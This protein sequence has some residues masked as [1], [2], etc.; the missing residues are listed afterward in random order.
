[1]LRG[2]GIQKLFG[3]LSVRYDGD[4]VEM[5]RAAGVFMVYILLE[6]GCLRRSGKKL[7]AG[8]RSGA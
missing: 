8:P 1:V 4:D 7:T 3:V 5:E 2:T 6:P